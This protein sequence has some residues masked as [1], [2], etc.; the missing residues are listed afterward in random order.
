MDIL[1]KP[2]AYVSNQIKKRKDDNWKNKDIPASSITGLDKFS[3]LEVVF[4]FNKVS[5]SEI[6]SWIRHPRNNSDYPKAGIFS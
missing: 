5:S 1:I 2:M 3:H 4:Y 6:N